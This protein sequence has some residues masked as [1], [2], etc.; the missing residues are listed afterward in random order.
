MHAR[1]GL[2]LPS[3]LADAS[4]HCVWFTG[5]GNG[6]VTQFSH[7]GRILFISHY[8]A[9]D[10]DVVMYSDNNGKSYTLSNHTFPKM[11]EATI[12]EL[13]NG[14]IVVNMRNNHL[15]SCNCRGTAMSNDGGATWGPIIFDSVLIEPVC[16]ASYVR[17]NTQMYF[18][19]PDSI[20]SRSNLTIRR[21]APDSTVWLG[22]THLVA[23]GALWGGYSQMVP[24][25]LSNGVGGIIFERIDT[26]RPAASQDVISFA[27]F[28]LDF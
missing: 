20:S 14:S 27:T 12:A 1:Y 11:D 24:E 4:T 16:Q 18:S 23:G 8:G 21:T 26:S 6:I 28:P 3:H 13:T 10:Y 22:N 7:P 25:P 15:T 17:I 19:N 5:P 2:N 9:Y